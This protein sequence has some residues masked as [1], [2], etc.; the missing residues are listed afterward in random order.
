MLVATHGQEVIDP[1][2][3]LLGEAHERF[4]VFPTLLERDF[5]LP[6]LPRLVKEVPGFFSVAPMGLTGVAIA[7]VHW[8]AEWSTL[9]ELRQG[10]SI[11]DHGPGNY[12]LPAM[13]LVMFLP[14][15]FGGAGKVSPDA[16]LA[17]RAQ[18]PSA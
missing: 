12:K 16:R 3:D 13:Y 10:Y 6:P 15:L 9:A 4:G 11:G 17:E 7:S 14:L 5:N 18:P 1:V 8:P 2:W